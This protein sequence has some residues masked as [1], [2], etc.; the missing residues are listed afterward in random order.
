MT[1]FLIIMG[2][3][4]DSER[5]FFMSFLFFFL[6]LLLF[7]LKTCSLHCFTA[8]TVYK[9]RIV[10]ITSKLINITCFSIISTI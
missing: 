8:K 1:Q 10:L 3:V 6:F 5:G 9:A 2:H 4:T 7:I